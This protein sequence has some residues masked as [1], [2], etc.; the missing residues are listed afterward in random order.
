MS[1]ESMPIV[2]SAAD[3]GRDQ[4]AMLMQRLNSGQLWG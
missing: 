4:L 3:A 2:S 1:M